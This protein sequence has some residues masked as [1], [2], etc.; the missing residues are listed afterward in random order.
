MTKN[1]S[2]ACVRL[3]VFGDFWP[4]LRPKNQPRSEFQH[5]RVFFM[6]ETGIINFPESLVVIRLKM[7]EKR[8]KKGQK[9]PEFP[10]LPW[11]PE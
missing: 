5:W 6:K 11:L 8:L 2:S 1:V 3:F 9:I 4:V 7:S 10:A